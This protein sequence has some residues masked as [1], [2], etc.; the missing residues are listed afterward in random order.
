MIFK[1]RTYEVETK[2]SNLWNDERK[3][4]DWDKPNNY[5][6]WDFYHMRSQGLQEAL[7]RQSQVYDF[8]SAA[9]R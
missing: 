1:G 7:Q 4:D 2:T 3:Q 8:S 9:V 6:L 5:V